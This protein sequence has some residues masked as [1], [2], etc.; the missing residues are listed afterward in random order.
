MNAIILSDKKEK[1]VRAVYTSEHFARLSHLVKIPDRIYKKE[2]ILAEKGAFTD[3]RFIFSTW[4][5]PIFE[6][7]E[8]SEIFP[9]LEAVFYAAGSVQRFARP[10]LELGIHVFSAWAANGIPVAEYTLAQITLAMKGF[11]QTGRIFKE[12]GH[13]E[14]KSCIQHFPGNYGASVGLIG[15]GM[16]GKMVIEKLRALKV[17]T[18]VFDPFL[19]DEKANELGVE[20]VDLSTL[21]SSCQVVS[22]HLANNPQT[23]GMLKK[24]H[25]AAMLPYATFLN[26]GRGAQVVEEDLISVLKDRPDLFAV[27][28]VTFPEPPAEDSEFYTLPNVILTPHIAGSLGNEVQ[29]MTDFIIEEADSFLAGKP[30]RYEVSLKMLETMA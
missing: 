10:F 4:G 2:D 26:T 16:I 20:K 27:L 7:E 14:A 5:M 11:F 21:F 12:K 6:K 25:F 23:Q 22:N 15:A 13:T 8:I 19:S 1:S 18:L 30:T 3:V 29:R 24:E 17:K 28:D 9:N